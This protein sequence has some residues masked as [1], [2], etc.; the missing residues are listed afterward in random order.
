M[1]WRVLNLRIAPAVSAGN[2]SARMRRR[3]SAHGC[4][5]AWAPSSI[6]YGC[7]VMSVP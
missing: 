6:G 5:R 2:S 7:G 3:P 1:Q 4:S